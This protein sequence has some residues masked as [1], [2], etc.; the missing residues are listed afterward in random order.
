[1]NLK[2]YAEKINP[3]MQQAMTPI[4]LIVA[5]I[6]LKLGHVCPVQQHPLGLQQQQGQQQQ[7][8]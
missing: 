1:L 8:K 4:K 5:R 3:K 2:I 7:I 6:T